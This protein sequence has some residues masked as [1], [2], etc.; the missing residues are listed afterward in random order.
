ME[1]NEI[2][3]IPAIDLKAGKC[4]RLYQGDFN[5]ETVFSE[6][7]VEVAL[8]WQSM[9]APRIHIVDL[10]GADT[11]EPHNL[12]IIKEITK[13]IWIP[14]QLGGG[15][16]TM[17]TIERFLKLGVERL[18]LGTIAVEEPELIRQACSRF[19]D[20]II[21]GVDTRQGYIATHAWRRQTELGVIDFVLSM[22]ELGVKRFIYTDIDRDGTL[23]QPNFVAISEL[24]NRVREPIVASGGISSLNHLIMLKK[25]GVEGAI[26]GRA[27]YVGDIQLKKALSEIG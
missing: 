12:A 22:V 27:L 2:E 9:G 24:I 5:Q 26:I 19:R 15:V 4:V 20:S 25:L 3:V 18:I 10:D 7:P 23:T 14:T 16:R 13:A 17:D 11:G 1:V 21:V 6:D 8:Y